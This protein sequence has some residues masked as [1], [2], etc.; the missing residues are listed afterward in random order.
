LLDPVLARVRAVPGVRGATMLVA[1]PFQSTG[2]DVAY[3]LPGEPIEAAAGR[4][5][6]DGLGADADFFRTLGIPLLRGRPF[7]AN[8]RENAAPVAIVDAALA[9]T[10]WGAQNPIGKQIGIGTKFYSVVGIAG[11]TRYRDLLHDRQ[12][13]YVPY[14]QS[15]RWGPSFIAVRTR[16]DPAAMARSVRTAVA[17]ADSL[18]FVSQM[19]TLG[20]R[21]SASTAQARLNAVLLGGFAIAILLLT[22]LGLYSIAA[23]YV[24][25]RE[26]EIAVRVA[27][28]AEPSRVVWLVLGQGVGVVVAGALLGV[29]GA[30]AGAGVL[31]SIV[32]GVR[33][34]DPAMFSLA[35][36][37]V[38]AV[39]LTAF[40]LPARRASRASPAQVLR[41]G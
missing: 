9:R 25:H 41:A 11:E 34:R 10:V 38:V 7:T 14:R 23:T 20:E 2:L 30:L 28:G 27:M 35:L 4:A 32:Y 31:G 8:D 18:F 36:A 3:S 16:G 21:V 33:E 29:A 5:M 37:G 17:G 40:F 22:A 19:T 24:R 13:I 15:L 39:A 26:F 1:A 6:V 12:S